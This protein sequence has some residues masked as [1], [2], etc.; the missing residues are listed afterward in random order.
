MARTPALV[1]AH[2]TADGTATRATS[3]Y[4]QL[5]TDLLDGSLSPTASWP[6][7]P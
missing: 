1:T 4:D 5:R 6:P 7:R 3:R 2:G